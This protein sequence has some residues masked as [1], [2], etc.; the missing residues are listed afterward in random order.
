LDGGEA[1]IVSLLDAARQGRFL[2]TE[3]PGDCR[4]CDYRTVCRVEGDSWRV[5][6]S[7]PAAWGKARL[8]EGA[9]VYAELRRVRGFED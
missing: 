9:D 7:P 2:P 8:E 1:L 6:H 4:F 5:P 3:A